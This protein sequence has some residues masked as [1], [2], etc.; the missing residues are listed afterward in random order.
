MS[1]AQVAH[2]LLSVQAAAPSSAS[3][4]DPFASLSISNTL[5]GAG[6]SG[7]TASRGNSFERPGAPASSSFSL[8]PASGHAMTGATGSFGNPMASTAPGSRG[9]SFQ[10]N[11]MPAAGMGSGPSPVSSFSYPQQPPATQA[12][13]SYVNS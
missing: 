9:Q 10:S 2:P 6:V 4:N 5:G 3:I 8:A 12:Q 11:A 1:F 7:S 13:P